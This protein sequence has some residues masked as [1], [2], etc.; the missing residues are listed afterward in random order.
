MSSKFPT[1]Y[2]L[3][4]EPICGRADS[5]QRLAGIA[6]SRRA[7]FSQRVS[8]SLS[9]ISGQ[10][11]QLTLLPCAAPSLFQGPL[12]KGAQCSFSHGQ[13]RFC[14]PLAK[15]MGCTTQSL[16][17][18]PFWKALRYMPSPWNGIPFHSRQCVPWRGGC[19]SA[20]GWLGLLLWL[21]LSLILMEAR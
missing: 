7:L 5:P 21:L 16:L 10:Q 1:V 15:S 17:D 13:G 8:L 4:T 3:T 2:F 19:V 9:S 11:I 14:T 12:P 20:L 18:W 6:V